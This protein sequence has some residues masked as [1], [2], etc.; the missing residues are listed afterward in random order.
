M[1]FKDAVNF[2]I[3]KEKDA[4]TLYTRCK[5]I[6]NNNS[7]KKMFQELIEQEKGHEEMLRALD[8]EAIKE[9]S[10]KEVEDLKIGDFL[11]ETPFTPDVTYRDA[12]VMAIKR[13]EKAKEL[14]EILAK[15]SVDSDVKNLFSRLSTEE[16]KHKHKLEIEY[17]ENI[18]SEN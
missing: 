11:E 7:V 3:E 5:E 8:L 10:E 15:S 2:A 6:A 14:Y 18:L 12:L 1:K 16:A 4:Q 13:E 9:S 17:D